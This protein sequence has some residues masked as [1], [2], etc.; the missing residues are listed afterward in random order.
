MRNILILVVILGL[1]SLA[2]A[3]WGPVGPK[4]AY[5]RSVK[6]SRVDEDIIYAAAY[7]PS[8]VHI[9]STDRGNTWEKMGSHSGYT[10]CMAIDQNDV[11]YAGYYGRV[12]KST[13]GGTTWTSGTV[14]S[15]YIYG[16]SV[17]TTNPS[18]VYGCGRKYIVLGQYDMVFIKST[19]S[20]ST[21]TTI[22]LV[23]NGSYCY[24][25]CVAV[26]P[27]NPNTVYAGGSER[28]GSVYEPRLLKSTDG[29]SNFTDISSGFP[30]AGRYIYSA[31]V[32]PT[33]SNIVYAGTYYD[34][35]YRSTDGGS[36]WTKEA[37]LNYNYRMA[38]TPADPDI[39]FASSTNSIYRSIDAGD[40]WTTLS[41]GLYGRS[42]YGLS[43]SP[44]NASNVYLGNDTGFFK[45][46]N[47]GSNW[48]PS[49][50]NMFIAKIIGIGVAPSAPSTM[51]VTY[52]DV[53][54]YKTTNDGE[55]WT[56][57]PSFS[58]C[59]DMCGFGIDYSDANTVISLEGLG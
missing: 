8:G 59:G 12:Y 50:D 35:I 40:S 33:N 19:D 53:A 56:K 57:L 6:V 52:Q 9:R 28:V 20:G 25:Y 46:T 38:T 47:M 5:L 2:N 54:V 36:T 27:S 3:A 58:S 13:N 18:I 10:Y 49:Y 30:A 17:H 31:A 43:I 23:T 4:G 26:D 22:T 21:W 1:C 16:L 55:D 39:V 51:Y 32:H 37:S 7:Y 14:S 42:F 11:L 29:G 15:T 41:S 45:S 34:G 48:I 24:G 44:V